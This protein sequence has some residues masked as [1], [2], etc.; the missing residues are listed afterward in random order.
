MSY[1]LGLDIGTNSIGWCIIG[2][3]DD[4]IAD[5]I[6]AIGVRILSDGRDPKSKTSLNLA[7]REKRAMR[8]SRDRYLRRRQA[9]LN[10]LVEFEL[11]PQDRSDRK[12]LELL[13]PYTV[14][15]AVLYG[16]LPQRQKQ[17]L[18]AGLKM[19]PLNSAR[20]RQTR[21][22]LSTNHM[23]QPCPGAGRR[24]RNSIKA[25]KSR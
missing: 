24:D 16:P 15:A 22:R 25:R 21:S 4:G 18:V 20:R 11:L 17:R 6:K 1:S 7:R 9:L 14:R 19:P 5:H 23:P 3:S 2:Y 12:Q 10:L 13:N 8:R